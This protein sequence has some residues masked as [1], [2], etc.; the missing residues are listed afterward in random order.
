M[1]FFL[2]GVVLLFRL[3]IQMPQS[4]IDI[5]LFKVKHAWSVML[6]EGRIVKGNCQ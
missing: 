5:V 1:G 2:G 6:P 3:L 4:W